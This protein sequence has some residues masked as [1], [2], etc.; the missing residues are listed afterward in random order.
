MPEGSGR[1]GVR[2]ARTPPDLKDRSKWPNFGAGMA[3]GTRT[4]Q[5]YRPEPR[6]WPGP[7]TDSEEGRA[8]RRCGSVAAKRPGDFLGSDLA[9][10]PWGMPAQQWEH[11]PATPAGQREWPTHMMVPAVRQLI[12]HALTG[13]TQT[14]QD[15][16]STGETGRVWPRSRLKKTEVKS[17]R[18]TQ[19]A[20]KR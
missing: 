3:L 7:S 11:G 20:G 18:V 10:A 19:Q 16:K 1:L 6:P 5:P 13:R 9:G 12:P 14:P 4:Q 17:E 2:G 15:M 8:T